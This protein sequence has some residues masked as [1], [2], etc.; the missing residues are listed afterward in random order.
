MPEH[1][2]GRQ[3]R[4]YLRVSPIAFIISLC[5]VRLTNPPV[6][7]KPR[8]T[9][10]S[11]ARSAKL[12]SVLK[13]LV[14]YKLL[15]KDPEGRHLNHCRVQ[16]IFVT[17]FVTI[18]IQQLLQAEAGFG[19]RKDLKFFSLPFLLNTIRK[20]SYPKLC[21]G[22]QLQGYISGLSSPNPRRVAFS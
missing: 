18:G 7:K 22:C 3:T 14:K 1:Y 20:L 5:L 15:R 11:L 19:Y 17:I 9:I 13:Y 2:C 12:K 6:D 10:I 8:S 4:A 16:N 21:Y